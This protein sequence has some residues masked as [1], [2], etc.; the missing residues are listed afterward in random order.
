MPRSASEAQIKRAYRKLAV[1]MHPDKVGGNEEE[2]KEATDKFAQ[3]SHGAPGVSGG[4]GG[5]GAGAGRAPGR[6]D[7][8]AASSAD[9]R[10]P[11]SLS[12]RTALHC[13]RHAAAY[14]VLTDAEKR[15]VYDQHGEEGLKKMAG[16]GG[17][18]G[19][20][21]HDIFAQ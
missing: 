5:G 6:C 14:E 3:V 21:A 7:A 13:T 15:R 18:G 12:R 9:V 17:G 2:Q 4:G 20:S 19:G 1:K 11:P 16:G 10:L 8:S